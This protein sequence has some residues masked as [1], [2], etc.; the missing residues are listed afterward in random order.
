MPSEIDPIESA[1]IPKFLQIPFLHRGRTLEGADCWGLVILWYKLRLGIEL[2]DIEED[3]KKE[4]RRT[5]KNYFLE[6]YHL[7]WEKCEKPQKYDVVLFKRDEKIDHAGIFL[8]DDKFLHINKSGCMVCR[9]S[10]PVW[11]E[12]FEGFYRLKNDDQS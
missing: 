5:D 2:L 7:Q 11:T 8:R 12:R 9:L 4:W 1:L 10:N 6:H 3:Y